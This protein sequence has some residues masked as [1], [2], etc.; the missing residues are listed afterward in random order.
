MPTTCTAARSGMT[1]VPGEGGVN[2]MTANGVTASCDKAVYKS[3]TF[4]R[5][6]RARVLESTP[7]VLSIGSRSMREGYSFVWPA[8]SVPFMRNKSGDR[9][10][11]FVE[12]DI[13]YVKLGS[14]KS[15]PRKCEIAQTLHMG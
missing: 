6:V 1:V 4:G 10:D 3:K 9:I 15:I 5:S 7:A 13:P 12:N 2:F 14:K 11:L 8:A